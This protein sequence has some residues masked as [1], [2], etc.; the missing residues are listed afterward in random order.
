[1]THKRANAQIINKISSKKF[2]TSRPVH[3]ILKMDKWDYLRGQMKNVF[4]ITFLASDKVH[5]DL[6]IFPSFIFI[7]E[8]CVLLVLV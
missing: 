6:L 3:V 8:Q 1:M 5:W 2:Q 4:F 7:L